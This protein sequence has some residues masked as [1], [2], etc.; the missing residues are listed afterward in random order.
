M[1]EWDIDDPRALVWW[2]A[3]CNWA[4]LK[5]ELHCFGNRTEC[6]EP[7]CHSEDVFSRFEPCD[8]ETGAVLFPGELTVAERRKQGG[9]VH[10]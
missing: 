1:L 3:A 9:W 4:G 10:W 2:C 6:P 7:G 5:T 8:P